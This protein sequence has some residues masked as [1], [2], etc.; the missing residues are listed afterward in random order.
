MIH[1]VKDGVSV[2]TTSQ[3]VATTEGSL[4]SRRGEP[5][6]PSVSPATTNEQIRSVKMANR[7]QQIVTGYCTWLLI[8][9]IVTY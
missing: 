9:G 3:S 4:T 5:G 7:S 6:Q 1:I 8:F 2:Y